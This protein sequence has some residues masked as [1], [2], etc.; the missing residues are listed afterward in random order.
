MI[1][2]L[3][4]FLLGATAVALAN[5]H[6][7]QWRKWSSVVGLTSQ[8]FWFYASFTSHQWGVFASACLYT[9]AWARGFYYS[10]VKK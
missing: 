4:I 2:Q 1:A 3:G 7:P 6:R 10:W 8:P 5:D 9:A